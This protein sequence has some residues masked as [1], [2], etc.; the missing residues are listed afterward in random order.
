MPDATPRDRDPSSAS[1]EAAPPALPF[2]LEAMFP[3]GMRRRMVEV[4]GGLRVHVA[5]WGEGRP[6]L[7][8]HGNPSWGFLYRKIISEL[9]GEPLRIVVPDLIGLGLSDKPRDAA[10]HTLPNHGRWIGEVIDRLGLDELIF[11]GQDWGG[12]IGLAALER[13]RERLRGM[14]LLN[15]VIGPPRPDF[16][17][18][19]FHKFAR[20]PI[21]SDVVFR[22]G[23]PQNVMFAAQG[24]KTSIMGRTAL[25]YWWPLRHVRDRV[26][27]LALAR[28]V[29]DSMNHPSIEPLRVCQDVATSFRGPTS[30]VWGD[31]D[32]VLGR[33]IGHMQRLLPHASVTRTQG[34]HFLQEEVPREIAG[35][36]RDVAAKIRA[37]QAN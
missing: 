14:V 9:A 1:R 30:I 28:M 2:W 20:M 3:S 23:F 8:M 13:R 24:T 16:R 4:G 10:V 22:L 15:T 29:P 35:A 21:V 34:G 26:A 6:V 33:V 36:V 11:V 37:R 7:M 31:R 27:P 12:P 18:T 17:A 5:E 25:G 19:G 32:P